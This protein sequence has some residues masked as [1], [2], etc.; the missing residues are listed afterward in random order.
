MSS[1]VCV[2]CGKVKW[3]YQFYP[4]R[5]KGKVCF[6]S[7]DS[8]CIECQKKKSKVSNII[9]L[10]H[11]KELDEKLVTKE[12]SQEDAAYIAG[13]IDGEGCICLHANHTKHKTKT[14]TYV[15]RVRVTNTFPGIIEWINAVVGYG[16][17]HKKKKYN[18]I[19][20]AWEWG[21]NGRR[22]I[23]FLRQIYPYL[24]V[25]RLQAEVAFEFAET[26]SCPGQNKLTTETIETRDKLR[27]RMSSLNN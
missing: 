16:S 25:K 18:G 17:F 13:F 6:L 11:K 14:S 8:Y 20:Q 23:H 15:L 4:K 24:R 10:N 12:L 26:L 1:K 21:V 22:A 2:K 9:K 19:K 27:E 3:W 7:L 5:T